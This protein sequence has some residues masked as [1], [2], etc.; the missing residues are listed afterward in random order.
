[1]S[2]FTPTCGWLPTVSST[3]YGRKLDEELIPKI[4]SE[5]SGERKLNQT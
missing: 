3:K 5:E 2:L 4:H 1:L